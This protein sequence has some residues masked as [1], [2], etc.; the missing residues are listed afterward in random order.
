M[1][2]LRYHHEIADLTNRRFGYLSVAWPVGQKKDR[3]L[4]WLCFCRCGKTRIIAGSTL[5]SGNT[6]SCGCLHR[7]TIRT[8][9]GSHRPE[10][11]IWEAIIQRCTNRKCKS[12][13][14]YGGRGITICEHWRDFANFFHDVGPRP[15]PKLTIDR[16]N[17]DGNYEPGNVRWTDRR[18]QSLNSRRWPRKLTK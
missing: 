8:H 6:R 2:T 13:K 17:N 5:A 9:A 7:E 16:I 14:N 3:R 12:W 10:Y 15:D 18:T 4:Y 1:K 11:R